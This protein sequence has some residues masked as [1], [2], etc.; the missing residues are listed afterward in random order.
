MRD[1]HTSSQVCCEPK[2]ALKIERER[3]GGGEDKPRA[4]VN[5]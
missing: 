4:F 1:M 3:E 2:T 5:C